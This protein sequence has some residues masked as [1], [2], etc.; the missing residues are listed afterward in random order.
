M[1]TSSNSSIAPY[2]R[3]TEVFPEDQSQ[4]LIKHTNVYSNVANA[5]NVREIGIYDLQELLSGKKWFNT[6]NLQNMRS[7]YRKVFQIGPIN[8][9]AI[10]TIAHGISGIVAF[11]H[12]YGTCITSVVDYRPI[13]YVDE[14]VVTN[15]IRLNCSGTNLI[16]ANGATAPGITSGSIVLEYLLN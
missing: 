2:L 12:M 4:L 8:A 6:T 11:T 9:G 13:P 16:I 15:Q 14:T 1:T 5:V 7:V 3:T 10:Q